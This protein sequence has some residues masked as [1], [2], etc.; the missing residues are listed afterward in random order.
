MYRLLA[1]ADLFAEAYHDGERVLAQVRQPLLGIWGGDD[2]LTPPEENPPLFARALEQ[3][4]NTGTPCASSQAQSMPRTRAQTAGSTRL[5]ALAPGYAELVGAWVADVTAG[6]RPVA[7]ARRSARAQAW[8]SVPVPPSAW[9]NRPGAQLGRVR[10]VRRGRSW[11]AGG[12]AAAGAR[13]P[14]PG[15]SGHPRRAPGQRG[16]QRSARL[17]CVCAISADGQCEGCGAWARS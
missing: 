14:G 13:S 7:G 5:T 10:A 9:W 6:Q 4:G 12:A 8:P 15:A 17:L 11:P 2:L 16:R 3:G 1:D